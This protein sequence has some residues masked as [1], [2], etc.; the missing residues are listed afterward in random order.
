VAW[1]VRLAARLANFYQK[2]LLE[3]RTALCYAGGC[4]SRMYTGE[5]RVAWRVR[6]AARLA[7]F[8][9]K[10]GIVG[11]AMRARPGWGLLLGWVLE[12]PRSADLIERLHNAQGFVEWHN[13]AFE[14]AL[15]DAAAYFGGFVVVA[16]ANN[17]FLDHLRLLV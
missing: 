2:H 17:W 13:L 1:R 7:N 9:Q 4:T 3:S 8:Y 12:A 10:S 6:L 16:V 11:L 15:A 14:L 5:R